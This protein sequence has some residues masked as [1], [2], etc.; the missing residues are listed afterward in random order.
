[1]TVGLGNRTFARRLV[2]SLAGGRTS[3]GSLTAMPLKL[4]KPAG[5]PLVWGPLWTQAVGGV[6]TCDRDIF[7]EANV[8]MEGR[9]VELYP[10][11]EGQQR[12]RVV[13]DLLQKL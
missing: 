11:S 10:A 8:P 12:L 13:E 5:C 6:H 2:P 4:L 1:M 3:F 7:V 9:E